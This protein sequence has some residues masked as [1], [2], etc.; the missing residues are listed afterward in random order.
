MDGLDGQLLDR[1]AD[2]TG[3]AGDIRW[4]VSGKT[5]RIEIDLDGDSQADM[6]LVLTGRLSLSEGDFL[7]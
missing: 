3:E 7:L 2:F 6:G 5:T 4:F 1:S